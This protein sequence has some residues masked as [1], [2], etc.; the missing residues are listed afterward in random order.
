MSLLPNSF[1]EPLG[2]TLAF[3]K[4]PLERVADVLLS[5]W[6]TAL[7]AY[8]KVRTITGELDTLLRELDPMK[9]PWDRVLVIRTAT[10]WLVVLDN[11]IGYCDISSYPPFVAERLRA[12][13][14]I[15]I[16]SPWDGCR[17]SYSAVDGTGVWREDLRSV[18][19]L[20]EGGW[21]FNQ[22]GTPLEFEEVSQYSARR[23]RDRLT[24]EMVRRYLKAMGLPQ[25]DDEPRQYDGWLMELVWD[26]GIPPR[27]ESVEEVKKQYT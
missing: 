23:V 16:A 18:Y 22:Q 14:V 10:P 19:A 21:E 24:T 2:T 1:L 3:I 26:H 13:L 6:G 25:L 20:K 8:R 4:A 9:F 17:F 15:A 11:Q 5:E 12:D 7:D 27:I